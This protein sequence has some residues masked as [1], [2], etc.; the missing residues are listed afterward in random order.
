HQSST[1]ST[2]DA[3]G[4][5]TELHR[6]ASVWLEA[7]GLELEAFHHAAAANDNARA[8]RLIEGKGVPLHFRGAGAP[9]RTWL[10]SLPTTVLNA[11]PSLWVTYAS[12][13][14]MTGQHTAV[15]EKLQAAEA[16]LHGAEPDDNTRDLVGRIASMRA[17]V[18][19]IQHD[20]DTLLAQSRRALAYLHPD[21]LPLRT[22]AT[23]TL[24]YAYQL[25]GD[26]A[27]A[28]RAYADVIASSTSFGAS[29]YTT[30]ATLCLGQVQEADN[31]LHLAAEGYRR[32]L[33]LAG[34]PPRPM[35]G[36]AHLGL[37]RISYQWND[38]H[39]AE[40]HG[41]QCIQLMRQM[42]GVD[43]FASSGLFLARLRLAQGD[44][45][46]AGAVLEEADAFVRQ[47]NFAHRIP[48][49]AAAQVLVFLRQGHLAAAA[50][51]AATHDLP[52]SQARVHLARGDPS[53]A[54]ALLEPVRQQAEAKGWADERLTVMVL[55]ALALHA[56]SETDTAVH[57]LGDVLALA[58]PGGFIRLFVDEGAP[59][60]Q[61]LSAAAAHG[62]MPDYIGTLLAAVEAEEPKRQ[63]LSYLPPAHPAQPLSESLSPRE[64]EVLQLMA[65]GLS[66]REISERLFLA[67]STVKGHNQTIFGKLQV[68][69]RTE[70]VARARELGLV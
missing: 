57:V 18:A 32:V 36:E 5:V 1:A 65:Q 68:Q 49:V 39:A 56:Q 45:A 67:L 66:N 58:R 16:A 60:V 10:E 6:R 12:A 54:L 26:R 25:Q 29:I 41:K 7:H 11:S 42:E 43:T 4:E 9:V 70:A 37:A 31:Q 34:D 55:E 2:G 38:L 17:T 52:L 27:A 3:V 51:L 22:A 50:Q 20:V 35:A 15:E 40:Q 69:R 53:T 24:G 14:M 21:N 23:Y 30:A 13:L 59:M 19:V 8:E 47:H 61:L 28:S 48:E 62:M 33:L 46:G 64:R 63:D 44:V